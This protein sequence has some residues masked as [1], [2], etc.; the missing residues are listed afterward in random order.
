MG[1]DIVE[2]MTQIARQ[3]NIDFDVVVETLEAGLLAA[4]KKKYPDADNIS[5]SFNKS[6]GEITMYAIKTVVEKV[7]DPITQIS[8]EEAVAFDKSAQL[9]DEMEIF[10]DY[11]EFG[12]N[13][14]AS[15]KQIL[16]QRVREAE[17]TRIYDEYKD[18]VGKLVSGVVTQIDKTGLLVNLGDAEAFL[19]MRELIPRERFRQGD[20]LRAIITAVEE[21]SRGPQITLSRVSDDFLEA[22]FELEVPEIYEKVIEIK[23]IAREPGER[24]KIAVSS[25]DD[26]ID[27]IGACVG[28]KGVRV[29]AVVRELNNERLD[30][31]LYSSNPELFV[32]RSLSPAKVTSIDI[33]EEDRAMTVA[34]EDEKLSLA[35]GRGGQNAR[36]AS[37]LT[38]WRIN[39]L[40]ESEY[41]LIKRREAELMAP[42]GRME[43]IGPKMEERLVEND[44]ISVQKLAKCTVEE[45]TEIEGIG[46]TT[47]EN[48]I[49]RA[50]EMSRQIEREYIA[51]QRELAA[52]A[53]KE[54]AEK[55]DSEQADETGIFRKDFDGE[56]EDESGGDEEEDK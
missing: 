27:P 55:D 8:L 9:G 40:S 17:R 22:L 2:A 19:P 56:D 26:R 6:D 45:L 30:I 49:S 33:Y 25:I 11:E 36:L 51:E 42:V 32:T 28:I 24:A 16:I 47:A 5:F 38:G 15:A 37:R 14:V 34:V 44:I 41:N 29:Q 1:Y 20:R 39:I 53:E 35:I 48:L 52:Q 13:A 50:R 31:V 46:D 54:A 10:L 23:A 7:E 3:K 43:G 4:A 18:R 12:R 21:V